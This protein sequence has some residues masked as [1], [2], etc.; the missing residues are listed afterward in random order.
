M[1]SAAQK[2]AIRNHRE[3]LRGRGLGRFEVQGRMSDKELL[4][5]LARKL[6]QDGP[7]A[8]NVRKAVASAVASPNEAKGSIWAAL[9]RSPLVRSELDLERVRAEPRKI[10]L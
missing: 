5:K 10:E 6:A 7:S 9:R 8:E 1:T 2:K 3:R 4:R